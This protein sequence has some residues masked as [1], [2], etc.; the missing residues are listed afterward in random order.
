MNN[1]K[2]RHEI[3]NPLIFFFCLFTT[4]GVQL[5]QSAVGK[6]LWSKQIILLGPKCSLWPLVLRKFFIPTAK[7]LF[8]YQSM[9]TSCL[10]LVIFSEGSIIQSY[11]INVLTSTGFFSTSCACITYLEILIFD[12]YHLEEIDSCGSWHV[13]LESVI[14]FNQLLAYGCVALV[15][16]LQVLLPS[17][18][19]QLTVNPAT[20]QKEFEK[21]I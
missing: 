21:W 8:S 17:Q 16:F 6:C 9:L 2:F 19:I 14:L 7:L 10:A 1:W 18:P 13:P 12:T 15:T 4:L 5:P 11:H 3:S 20:W